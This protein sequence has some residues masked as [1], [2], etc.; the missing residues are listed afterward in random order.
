MTQSRARGQCTRRKGLFRSKSE[1][2]VNGHRVEGTL[3]LANTIDTSRDSGIAD[4]RSEENITQ[5]P[6]RK[7]IAWSVSF[8]NDGSKGSENENGA[9]D[10]TIQ[11]NDVTQKE[12]PTDLKVL[13][14]LVNADSSLLSDDEW[15][16][17][18]G[19]AIDNDNDED[20]QN[21]VLSHNLQTLRSYG[22]EMAYMLKRAK[23]TWSKICRGPFP[24]LQSHTKEEVVDMMSRECIDNTDR[25]ITKFDA[26]LKD[27]YDV[28]HGIDDHLDLQIDFKNQIRYDR[29]LKGKRPGRIHLARTYLKQ[30]NVF[31]S[32]N[33]RDSLDMVAEDITD[34]T[35]DKRE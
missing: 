17:F 35:A 7:N 24:H 11:R 29:D 2:F 27:V 6:S 28:M 23:E 25:L 4:L 1:S 8:L 14:N 32:T 20:D 19:D 10:D 15:E 31:P 3:P 16:S 33:F 22:D 21:S 9:M 12:T 34:D 26:A 18:Q 30:P 5:H 13:W